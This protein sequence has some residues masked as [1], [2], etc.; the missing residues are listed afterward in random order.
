MAS[1]FFSY[2]HRDETLR[3]QLE[4]HLQA[5]KRQGIIEMW[6][7]R[8][9]VAGEEWEHGINEHLHHADII[10]LL[11]SPDFIASDYC[12]DIEVMEALRRHDMG[13]ARVIP[14]ILRP[15]DWHG[16]PFGKLQA[17]PSDGKPVTKFPSLDD[18]FLEVTQA[19]KRA[20]QRSGTGVSSPAADWD[21]SQRPP[22]SVDIGSGVR[23]S[24]LHVKRD[25]TDHDKD[26]FRIQSFEYIANYFE[27]SLKELKTRNPGIETAFRQIDRD[28]FEATAYKSGN[29]TCHCGIWI[30]D[31]TGFGKQIL[32]SH[33]GRTRNSYNDSMS[34]EDDGT[35]LGLKPIGF[36]SGLKAVDRNQ[37][38]TQE[39]AAEY[40][41]S[42]F[43]E[44]LQR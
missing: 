31:G 12:Y 13:E 20:I 30:S 36:P 8:R 32:F 40:Y 43:I 37:L 14:V 38:L 42:L 7:D 2:C 21:F 39:G 41:W 3:D 26:V 28:G 23:S 27:N 15:C 25:F 11:V 33:S 18:A 29:S 5:L 22:R 35:S 44:P 24:N 16:L 9:L 17:T 1:L 19:I 6:H 4:I 10:L 34:I